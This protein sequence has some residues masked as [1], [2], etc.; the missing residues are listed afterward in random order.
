MVKELL[1][2]GIG[3]FGEM[4]VTHPGENRLRWIQLTGAVISNGW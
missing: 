2:I 4:H 1:T 3:G